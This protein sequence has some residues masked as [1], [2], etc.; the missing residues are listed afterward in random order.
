MNLHP[1]EIKVLLAF[2]ERNGNLKVSTTAEEIIDITKLS[3]ADLRRASG[4]LN[5]KKL[6]EI[7]PQK[8]E[9]V[10]YLT[11][12]GK[13]Y[14]KKGTPEKQIVEFINKNK[15]PIIKDIDFL[16]PLEISEAIGFLKNN[17]IIEIKPGG[18]LTIKNTILGEKVQHIQDLINGA[19][20]GMALESLTDQDKKIIEQRH[21]ERGK[22]KGI[23]EIHRKMHS[24]LKL[25]PQ[26]KQV[27][28]GLSEKELAGEE[29]SQL[30]PEMIKDGKWREK[31]FREYNIDLLPPMV[32]IGK[33]HPY[34]E[35]LQ[36]VRE[37]LISMGFKEVRGSIVENEFW[38]MDALYIPQFH[39]ARE[40][41]DVYF[42]K[43]PKY[44]APIE[45]S[46]LKKVADTHFNGG[47]TGSKGWRYKFDKD[48]ARRL[49]L[50]SQGTPLSVRTLANNPDIPGKYFAIARCFRYDRVDATHAPDFF[51]IEGI[52]LGKDINFRHLLGLLK[53][54]GKE[55]AQA[56][57]V[58]FL[59]TYFPFTEPSV[60]L[61]ARH[62]KLGG[63]T[64]SWVELGGAG[65]FRP[66][67]TKPFGIEVPVIAWGLGL[68]RMAMMALNIKDIR[69]LFSPDL[70]F[71]RKV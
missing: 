27:L 4:W 35:F 39:P 25:T 2:K 13:K 10:I 15:T 12:L 50:R 24:L 26:G 46:I 37:K 67:V 62:K 42:I 20:N 23:F 21:R 7:I 5:T 28:S 45:K 32:I 6:I 34:G 14:Y 18:V 1:L 44:S 66:E 53:L 31:D 59:P 47:D 71:L 70:E 56:D 55:I 8:P 9:T 60:E 33:K 61:Q 51:Q 29:I 48:R 63:I 64:S 43:E 30:T 49:I 40:V 65:I 69:D 19:Y 54:F 3:E 41:H 52:V 38:N 11:D 58:R 36:S 16:E 57:E 68:D 22:V 17:G